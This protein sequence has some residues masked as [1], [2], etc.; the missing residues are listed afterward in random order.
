MNWFSL[1]GGEHR[2]MWWHGI[3]QRS[4]RAQRFQFVSKVC[5]DSFLRLGYMV[6]D[7]FGVYLILQFLMIQVAKSAQSGASFWHGI[8]IQAQRPAAL[9][10]KSANFQPSVHDQCAAGD[11]VLSAKKKNK[12]QHHQMRQLLGIDI[13]VFKQTDQVHISKAAHAVLPGQN[14]QLACNVYAFHWRRRIRTWQS[15]HV[16]ST[17]QIQPCSGITLQYYPLLTIQHVLQNQVS[18]T[19]TQQRTRTHSHTVCTPDL[20]VHL[21]WAGGR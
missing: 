10:W 7:I 12:S 9:Q 1:Y 17:W 20:N 5:V 6:Y 13:E 21:L 18:I 8:L 2:S 11:S 16:S 14:I 15:S 19:H 4:V 3:G